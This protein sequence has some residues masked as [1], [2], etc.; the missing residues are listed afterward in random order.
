M[1]HVAPSVVSGATPGKAKARKQ[2]EVLSRGSP[3]H[4]PIVELNGEFQTSELGGGIGSCEAD[5]LANI[6]VEKLCC[7]VWENVA[8]S[9]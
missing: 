4:V 5:A 2:A 9:I 7:P 3:L 6:L 8:P 1:K